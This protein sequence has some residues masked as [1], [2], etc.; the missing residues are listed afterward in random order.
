M[1]VVA[2][3]GHVDHGKSTL[4]HAL[5]GVDPDR[6]AAEKARGL[7][8]ELGFAPLTLPSGRRLSFVDVPGHERL[9]A[10]ML[11]GAGPSAACLFVVDAT[12]GWRAQSEEH[13]RILDLLAVGNA[14]VAL[15]R[16]DAV[17]EPATLDG[18][19]TDVAHRLAGTALAGAPVVAIDSRSRR[20]LPDL[21]AALD[22]MVAGVATPP[23]SGQPRLWVDRSFTVRGAGTV[24]T[25]TLAGG[26]VALD[27]DLLTWPAQRVVGVRGLEAHGRALDVADPGTRIALNLRAIS[28]AEVPRG[29]LIGRAPVATTSRVGAVLRVL[30]GAAPVGRRGAHLLHL[31]TDAVAVRVVPAG[32]R[33][34]EPD[35]SA[36]VELVLSQPR[37]LRVGDRFVVRDAGRSTTVAGG[38]ITT[39]STGA[40]PERAAPAPRRADLG[41]LADLRAH[42]FDPPRP[43][44]HPTVEV[45]A[46]REAGLALSVEGVWFAREAVE[47]AADVVVELLEHRPEGVRVGEV[48]EA[49]A[50]SRRHALALLD[51]LDQRGVTRREGDLRFAGVA[52]PPLSSGVAGD[53]A[54]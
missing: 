50:T 3:A 4:V 47:A 33:S 46:L 14:V 2:T 11:A 44:G 7:T 6:L 39:L 30:A 19:T 10:T 40:P 53:R 51:L 9:V 38:S 26:R 49:L 32:G 54:R 34:V 24:V 17:A 25:G 13:L 43:D 37:P 23:D 8:L 52:A 28:P 18:V 41:Y 20:G 45:L 31:G 22:Q 42:P 35:T 36:P 48:R 12:E 16:C 29:S 15:T 1:T 5:T 21:V 27:D